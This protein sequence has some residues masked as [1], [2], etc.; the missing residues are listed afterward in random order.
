MVPAILQHV[1]LRNRLVAITGLLYFFLAIGHIPDKVFPHGFDKNAPVQLILL[2]LIATLMSIFIF[3]K[4]ERFNIPRKILGAIYFLVAALL[5]STGL[6]GNIINSLTGDTGR[7][8][9]VISVLALITVAIF[10]SQF[11]EDEIRKLIG[12]Y[13]VTVVIVAVLGIYQ[14]MGILTFPGAAGISS[15]FGNPDFFAALLGTT[16]PLFFYLAISATNQVRGLIAIGA[17]TSVVA[18]YFAGPLQAYVDLGIT[19]IG[20]IV[21]LV[22]RWIPRKE[23]S[24]NVRTFLGTFGVIIWAEGI[25]LVPFIGKFIPVLGSDVQVQIRSNFW[26]A[27]LNQFFKNPFFGVGPD[28]YGNYYEQTR[29]VTD[30]RNYTDI[31]SNDAHSASIQTLGTLGFVGTLAFIILIAFT[32]RAISIIYDRGE[33]NRK[34]LFALTL[35][36]FVYLTNSFVSP[37]VLSHKYIFWS[38]CGYLIGRAYLSNRVFSVRNSKALLGLLGT[39]TVL[40]IFIIINFAVGQL[41]WLTNVEKYAADNSRKMNYVSSKYIPCQQ[42]FDA[43][44]IMNYSGGNE[45]VKKMAEMRVAT[46]PR[47]VPAEILLAKIAFNEGDYVTARKHIDTLLL[48]APAR[49]EV[50][51]LA[52][53]L[54]NKTKDIEFQKQLAQH[55][56]SLGLIYVAGTEG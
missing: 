8:V 25:F 30:I 13:L 56:T 7:F 29:T 23:L 32:I 4:R 11:S 35:F 24:L 6:S 48:I 34:E 10:H 46:N 53:T 54:S 47:C 50:L 31:L 49:N 20:L 43:E 15:T 14:K 9:G 37:I 12:L 1:F 40:S 3:L 55:L 18:M 38:L 22:R 16:F 39:S 51:K 27:G 42:Y 28:N 26:L 2:V 19:F 33:S 21:F 52:I 45:V 41:N 36:L 17:V 44:L 5:I